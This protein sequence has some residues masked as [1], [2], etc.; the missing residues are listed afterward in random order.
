MEAAP[1]RRPTALPLALHLLL[2]LHS[3]PALAVNMT[4][5]SSTNPQAGITV[6]KYA[7]T[8]PKTN[9]WAVFVDLCEARIQVG[10]TKAPTAI[11]TASSWG[12]GIGVQLAVN[13]DFYKTGPV[14][15]YGKAIGDGIEW[16][17]NQQ[18]IDPGYSWEWFYQKF[19]WIAFGHDFVE[20][21]HSKWVKKNVAGLT[22]GWQPGSV[23]TTHPPGTIAL[24]SGFS[25][26]VIE[27]TPVDC[28]S[29]TADDCFPDR[30]DMRARH[31]RTAMGITED[32]Q[33]FILLVVDGR[34]SS[35]IGMYGEELA[36][37]MG[38]LGAYEAFNLDG[39][40]S[41]QLWVSGQG[42]IN[43]AKGNN[44]GG[45]IRSVANHWGIF[46]G[47]AGGKPVRPGHCVSEPPCK[48][49][50]PGGGII[51]DSDSCFLMY[52]PKE[53]WRDENVGH[54]GGLHWTNAWKTSQPSNWAWWRIHLAEAG[55]YKVEYYGTPAYSVFKKVH[56]EVRANNQTHILEI[57]QSGA[58]GWKTLGTWDFKEGGE[59]WVA[60]FD[61]AATSPGSDQHV[62][63][64]A[65]RLTRTGAWCGNGACDGGEDCTSCTADCGA[66]PAC[67]D[68]DCN[69]DETCSNCAQD[70]GQ[71]PPQCGDDDCNGSETCTSCPSDCG[72]C[73]DDCGDGQ[74]SN[75][76]TCQSCPFDC[77]VCNNWCGDG[78]C[79]DNESCAVCPQDCGDCPVEPECGDGTCSGAETCVL[80]P[81][82]CGPCRV[83]CG[84]GQCATGEDCDNCP[85]DCW[86]CG[87]PPEADPDAVPAPGDLTEADLPSVDAS[88]DLTAENVAIAE[89]EPE[90]GSPSGGCANS[91][92]G[93]PLTS[94]LLLL[95]FLLAWRTATRSRCRSQRSARPCQ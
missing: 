14:R 27:G 8:G 58:S 25:E 83:Q 69:G 56:Y 71:C 92:S 54:G 10:A 12:A 34:T 67:G 62:V 3:L 13:G 39:G 24:V 20:F 42:T 86:P 77:G 33:T 49:L 9:L 64:D 1:M 22:A 73:P 36:E 74:C 41:S 4:L 59:Q 45:S 51:D 7:T 43:D 90:S 6:R 30:S 5:K 81:V 26:L 93:T 18:G 53:Y 38:K 11:K 23:V 84:D 28:T 66:C 2:M 70:C 50:S 85:E 72:N 78:T 91:T 37:V 63:A 35:S 21:N 48:V 89:A 94:A 82:D 19:G 17:L 44:N 88:V 65:I 40:G 61:D 95:L 46:A 60:V 76:E 15:V 80:C 29:P 31:P 55:E 16:P 52:G 75:G 79:D 87:G 68:G 57:N 32:R 47:T